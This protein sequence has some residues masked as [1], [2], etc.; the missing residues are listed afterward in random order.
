M[1]AY[2]IAQIKVTDP[3]RFEDYKSLAPET[4]TPFGGAYVVRGGA[5]ETLEGEWS[6]E[7]VV[8]LKF[9]GLDQAKAWYASADYKKAREV[10]AGAADFQV[11]AIEGLPE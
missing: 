9:P 10:R 2:V 6:P 11:L 5:Y 7:R 3:A 8:V 1:S 4:L